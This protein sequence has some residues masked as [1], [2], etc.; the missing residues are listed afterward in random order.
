MSR[1]GFRFRPPPTITS[2]RV[3]AFCSAVEAMS[4]AERW[5]L[6]YDPEY[7]YL[8]ARLRFSDDEPV[9][10]KHMDLALELAVRYPHNL[11]YCRLRAEVARRLAASILI[12]IAAGAR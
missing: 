7:Q 3:D 9:P 12:Q 5:R 2:P 11:E 8:M 4:S 1:P 6:E 10:I